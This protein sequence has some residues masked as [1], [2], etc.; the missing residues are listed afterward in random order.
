MNNK[1]KK[2]NFLIVSSQDIQRGSYFTSLLNLPDTTMIKSF[3]DSDS[4]LLYKLQDNLK[5]YK[6]HIYI[7]NNMGIN[8]KIAYDGLIYLYNSNDSYSFLKDFDDKFHLIYGDKNFPT[9]FVNFSLSENIQNK[10]KTKFPVINIDSFDN[11]KWNQIFST[12]LKEIKKDKIDMPPYNTK[13]FKKSVINTILIKHKCI[14][15]ISNYFLYIM[16]MTLSIFDLYIVIK[17]PEFVNEI[18]KVDEMFLGLRININVLNFIFGSICFKYF[19]ENFYKKITKVF[20]FGIITNSLALIIE[21]IIHLRIK[22]YLSYNEN[23][24]SIQFLQ[25]LVLVIYIVSFILFKIL[26]IEAFEDETSTNKNAKKVFS[27][28]TKENYYKF[29]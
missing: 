12:L 5:N 20:V 4:I 24:Y 2:K 6:L 7:C 18:S 13:Y 8:Q 9:V 25:M 22:K 11:N 26:N 16:L 3:N 23:Y 17:I 28:K 29:E 10:Y 19:Y 15:I 14:F 1:I 21:I 27:N